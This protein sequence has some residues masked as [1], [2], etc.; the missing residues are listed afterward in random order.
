MIVETKRKPSYAGLYLKRITVKTRL[1]R[2]KER[3][4]EALKT[5]GALEAF[6]DDA[7]LPYAERDTGAEELKK[8][9]GLLNE[10]LTEIKAEGYTPT[11]REIVKGFYK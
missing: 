1:D 3:Y 11:P 7:S 9:S 6:V 4:N 8:Q 10:T 5:L 2:L